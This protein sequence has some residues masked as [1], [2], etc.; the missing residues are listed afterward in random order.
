MA[1]LDIDVLR[2][3]VAVCEAGS[4]TRAA[5][6]SGRSQAAISQQVKHLERLAGQR[7]L[8]RHGRGVIVS[9]AGERFL[10]T[11][12]QVLATLDETLSALRDEPPV[13][14]I[15]IGLPDSHNHER[16]S[17]ALAGFLRTNPSVVVEVFSSIEDDFAA[18]VRTGSL[19]AAIFEADEVPAGAERLLS[20]PLIWQASA[21]FRYD[22]EGALPIVA[23]D[24][25]CWWS[26][27]SR[28]HLANSSKDF[29]IVFSGESLPSI[30]SAIS[31]GLGV[32]LLPSSLAGSGLVTFDGLPFGH[33]NHLVMI[34]SEELPRTI[35][36]SLGKHIRM[37]LA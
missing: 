6:H 7:L 3:F 4:M 14:Q 15:R 17:R 23:F 11:A 16:L 22:R 8:V 10:T 32:G 21:E 20:D 26:T 35:R 28:E 19:D 29:R 25:A 34:C 18:A 37:G 2:T 1:G 24:R 13:Q 30:H 5:T 31:N 9:A 33:P 27:V 36:Q 12:R